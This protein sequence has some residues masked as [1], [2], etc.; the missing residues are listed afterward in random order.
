VQVQNVLLLLLLLPLLVQGAALPQPDKYSRHLRRPDTLFN[1][2]QV[3]EA[4]AAAAA[5]VAASIAAA[6]D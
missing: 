2:H 5:T 1:R 3:K 6:V 4:I